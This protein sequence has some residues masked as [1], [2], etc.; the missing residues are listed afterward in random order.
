MRKLKFILGIML[1]NPFMVI[2]GIYDLSFNALNGKE[3]KFNEFKGKA[4]L[5][6]NTASGCGYT[7]QLEGLQK[8]HLKYKDKGLVVLGFPAV[9]FNQEKLENSKIGDFCRIN[10]GVSFQLFEKSNVNGEKRNSIYKE[11]LSEDEKIGWNFE[12]ILVSKD[13]KVISRYK[14][15]VK[16]LGSELVNDI[17]KALE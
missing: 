8:L 7:P 15:S 17:D 14:S 9:D 13:G 16:P 6:V 11:L 3:I 1:M 10:Y 12:K 2:G 5:I 4:L